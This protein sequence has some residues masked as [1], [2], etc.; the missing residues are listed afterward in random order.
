MEN[1]QEIVTQVRNHLLTSVEAGDKRFLYLPR[2]LEQV[3]LWAKKLLK[4]HPEADSRVVLSAVWL[5]D[6]GLLTGDIEIDHAVNSAEEA[7][8]FLPKIG[9]APQMIE[10]ILHCVRAHRCRDVMPETLEA[11]IVAAAD[12]ASHMTDY[13]YIELIN[14]GKG[15]L[16]PDKLER[17]FKDVGMFPELKNEITPLYQAWKVLINQ[18]PKKS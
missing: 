3:E 9:L 17:D 2:H 16:V 10:Q 11:K 6:I 14:Q 7:T 12:S 15:D 18:W 5:H 8:R 1:E 13:V 4:L